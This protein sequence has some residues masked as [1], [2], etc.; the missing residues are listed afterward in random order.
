MKRVLVFALALFTCVVAEAQLPTIKPRTVFK[1]P[2]IS[3]ATYGKY[4]C[5]NDIW[6]GKNPLFNDLYSGGAD[7]Y[8]GG[9]IDNVVASSSL[10]SQG[11]ATYKV[12]NVCDFNHETAWVEGVQGHGIGQWI[13]FQGVRGNEIYAINILNG[14][15]KSDKAWSENSRVKRLKVYCNGQAVCIFELQD[16]RSYQSFYIDHLIKG[17]GVKTFVFQIM[18]VYPGTK[19]QDTVISEIY[20]AGY[21]N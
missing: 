4:S 9:L 3:A 14:Y 17:K 20:L 6:N 10:S 2:N 16:S 1:V 19:Y 21:A 15:V 11:S 7:W 8:G 12:S 18:D 5:D 13:K